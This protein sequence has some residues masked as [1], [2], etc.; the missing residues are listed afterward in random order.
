MLDLEQRQTGPMAQPT[1]WSIL[2]SKYTS[3]DL[4]IQG[5]SL[6]DGLGYQQPN[7]AAIGIGNREHGWSLE[8]LHIGGFGRIGNLGHKLI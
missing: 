4:E 7:T 2:L 5:L 6:I 1:S 3:I 8:C